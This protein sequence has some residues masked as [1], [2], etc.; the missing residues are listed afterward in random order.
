MSIKA[1]KYFFFLISALIFA[2][3]RNT[4]SPENNLPDEKENFGTLTEDTTK[5]ANDSVKTEIKTFRGDN[6]WGYDI[7]IDSKIYIHQPNIPSVSG[8]NGFADEESAKRCGEFIAFKI[9]NHI[10]PPSVTPEELDS[11]K[12]MSPDQ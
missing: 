5:H 1:A 12:V 7:F 3:C 2:A 9:R 6:G 4:A 11:L 8:T 10:L